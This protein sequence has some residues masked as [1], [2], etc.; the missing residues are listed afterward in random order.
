MGVA[1]EKNH[2][3]KIWLILIFRVT[4]SFPQNSPAIIRHDVIDYSANETVK[5]IQWLVF[6]TSLTVK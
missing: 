1:R 4:Q 6:V 5:S 2:Y 3:L